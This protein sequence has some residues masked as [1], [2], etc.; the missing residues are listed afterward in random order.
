IGIADGHG[1]QQEGVDDRERHRVDANPDGQ[2]TGGRGSKP[3]VFDEQ[4]GGESQVLPEAHRV[5]VCVRS[6][7]TKRQMVLSRWRARTYGHDST[8]LLTDAIDAPAMRTTRSASA[9][10]T[11]V[12]RARPLTYAHLLL[13]NLR[14]HKPAWTDGSSTPRSRKRF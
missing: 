6:D 2:H 12:R 10:A 4:A 13:L 7:V 1:T 8:R 5:T 11:T 3:P 9:T 14:A